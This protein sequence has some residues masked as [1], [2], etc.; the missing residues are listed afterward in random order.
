MHLLQRLTALAR[1]PAAFTPRDDQLQALA[2]R[3]IKP[4][5]FTPTREQID[6]MDETAGLH[7]PHRAPAAS[8]PSPLDLGSA[9]IERGG[10]VPASTRAGEGG[11][12]A[13]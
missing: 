9:G 10:E 5:P 2:D 1:Q 4:V 6:A 12:C 7:A 3:G 11:T 8:A 13:L